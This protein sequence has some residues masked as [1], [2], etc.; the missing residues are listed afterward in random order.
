[1]RPNLTSNG[2]ASNFSND[3]R[4]RCSSI[5]PTIGASCSHGASSAVQR[6]IHKNPARI[7]ATTLPAQSFPISPGPLGYGPDR[8]LPRPL[9]VVVFGESG[10]GKSSVINMI[11]GKNVTKTSNDAVG[12]TFCHQ[13][14]E[15]ILNG[16]KVNL[17]DTAGLDEGTEGTVPAIQAEENLK[18]FLRQVTRRAG[19]DLLMYCVRGTRLRKALLRNYNI[20]YA[21]ICRKKVPVALIVTG[22]ENY[23]GEMDSWWTEHAEDL[24]KHG[25]RFDA[26]ACVTTIQSD[27]PA[28][29]SR[30]EHSRVELRKLIQEN[31]EAITWRA[32]EDSLISA[33]LPDVRALMGSRWATEKRVVP[34]IM[35][36]DTTERDQRVHLAPGIIPFWEKRLGRINGREYNYIRA[37]EQPVHGSLKPH[38][39]VTQRPDLL[40][41]YVAASSDPDPTWTSLKLFHSSYGGETCPLIVVFKGLDNPEAAVV[42]W[43]ALSSSHGGDIIAN[44]TFYP[45]PDAPEELVKR[46]DE[47]LAELIDERCL[48]KFEE[49]LTKVQKFYR[50]S[51]SLFSGHR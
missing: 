37:G 20:F 22:L 3:H 31:F 24:V 1:M 11:A 14:H 6:H 9:N 48:L 41:F 8:G 12:C 25:M 46:A 27:H 35:I 51:K 34:L 15:V 43:R 28:I 45:D 26:H 17:W 30:L 21:A 18:A 23:E 42:L 36:C 44:P 7:R 33:S 32:D 19:I 29:Q 10:V 38:L 2:R 4:T 40:V 39:A 50:Y 49:K 47:A 5:E 16:L 13:C